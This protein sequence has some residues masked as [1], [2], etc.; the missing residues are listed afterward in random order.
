MASN[1]LICKE[2]EGGISFG[3]YELSKKTKV[4]DF[5]VDGDLYK[6]KTFSEITKLE[7]NGLFLYESLPGT[8]VTNLFETPE[9]IEFTVFGEAEVQITVGLM[10][11]TLYEV[12]V[13][14]KDAG[15]MK[16]N[17][18]GKLSLSVDL[19]DEKSANIRIKR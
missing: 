8:K 4:E 17:V 13:N 9:G 10:E 2:K 14:E 11:D 16:T 6:V 18:G 5:P 1:G 19:T 7:K 12:F 15:K 3:N